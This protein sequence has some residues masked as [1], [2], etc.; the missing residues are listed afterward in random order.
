M[1]AQKELAHLL[2]KLPQIPVNLYSELKTSNFGRLN[3]NLS[4][5]QEFLLSDYLNAKNSILGLQIPLAFK[6]FVNFEQNCH[7][8]YDILIGTALYR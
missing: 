2:P 8:S 6:T 5:K 3:K 4:E 1:T 7:A